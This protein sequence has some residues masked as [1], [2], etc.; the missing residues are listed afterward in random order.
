MCS[1]VRPRKFKKK[2]KIVNCCIQIDNVLC[3]TLSYRKSKFFLEIF[4]I[5]QRTAQAIA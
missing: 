3:Y 4:K 5:S 2:K 1:E